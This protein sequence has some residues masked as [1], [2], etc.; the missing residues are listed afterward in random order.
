MLLCVISP[1]LERLWDNNVKDVEVRRI[2]SAA[3]M[4]SQR[5]QFSA[6]CALW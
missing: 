4:Y 2:L 6:V 1:N 5:I 3:K